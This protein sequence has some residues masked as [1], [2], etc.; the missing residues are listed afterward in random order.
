MLTKSRVTLQWELLS[1]DNT[2]TLTKGTSLADTFRG[3]WPSLLVLPSDNLKEQLQ[4]DTSTLYS[5]I[6]T[7]LQKDL[8]TLWQGSSG[9]EL[10]GF[11]DRVMSKTVSSCQNAGSDI[12]RA[13]DMST[14]G[15][16]LTKNKQKFRMQAVAERG[17]RLLPF[18]ESDRVLVFSTSDQSMTMT[19]TPRSI[20][21]T[22]TPVGDGRR[23]LITRPTVTQTEIG[24]QL[25]LPPNS[26]CHARVIPEGVRCDYQGQY[27]VE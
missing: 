19:I 20:S 16:R 10:R 25:S 1:P 4:M 15:N 27:P 13:T 5:R 14:I 11:I 7:A 17:I 22:Y 26:T 2:T 8:Q 21:V 3:S 18:F 23:P 24:Y 12:T 9:R 6:D